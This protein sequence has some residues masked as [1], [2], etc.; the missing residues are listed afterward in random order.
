[1]VNTMPTDESTAARAKELFPARH[2]EQCLQHQELALATEAMLFRIDECSLPVGLTLQ[3]GFSEPRDLWMLAHALANDRVLYIVHSARR[4]MGAAQFGSRVSVS[5]QSFSLKPLSFDAALAKVLMKK[6]NWGHVLVKLQVVDGFRLVDEPFTRPLTDAQLRQLH[7]PPTHS[8]GH[9]PLER[10][11]VLPVISNK[12]HKKFKPPHN[13]PPK[14]D[15]PPDSAPPPSSPLPT[16][17][18]RGAEFVTRSHSSEGQLRRSLPWRGCSRLA[19]LL[20]RKLDTSYFSSSI[21]SLS[22]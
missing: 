16:V 7:V 12:E 18:Q 13:L 5:G 3:L 11:R 15:S 20:H 10:G 21:E 4:G 9:Q 6:M 8:Y 22:L 19:A 14:D 1:M 2:M 17:R